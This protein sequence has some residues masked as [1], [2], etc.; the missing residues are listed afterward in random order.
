M[1]HAN[2]HIHSKYSYDSDL[3][4]LDIA[5]DLS[6]SNFKYAAITDHVDF[7][8]DNTLEIM[9]RI[10][11]RNLEIDLIN[12]KYQGKIKL[13]KGIEISEPYLYQEQVK[14]L[15]ELELDYILGS[16]HE[17][18]RNATTLAEKKH[19]TKG[20][21]D[22]VLKLIEFGNVDAI[23][24]L[25][26]INRYL[27]NDYSDRNQLI[28][29]LLAAIEKGLILEINTSGRRRTSFDMFP[30]IDKLLLYRQLGGTSVTIGT[31][32]HRREELTDNYGPTMVLTRELKLNNGIYQKRIFE[33]L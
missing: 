30:S 8:Y 26:Y 14:S 17:I 33:K 27:K 28:E 18:E 4:L 6:E 32:A 21:Y 20:Y 2:M 11:L 1:R 24:H 31:D 23:G 22:K 15:E 5:Q 3:D 10:K 25:D 19:V 9:K 13:L 7:N 12:E 16:I 29:V